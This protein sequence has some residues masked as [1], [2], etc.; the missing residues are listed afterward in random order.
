MGEAGEY[1]DS[2]GKSQSTGVILLRR[3]FARTNLL[4]HLLRQSFPDGFLLFPGDEPG[5]IAGGN[6]FLLHH[7]VCQPQFRRDAVG[8]HPQSEAKGIVENIALEIETAVQNMPPAAPAIFDLR[9]SIVFRWAQ[10]MP[11]ER[12]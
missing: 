4:V 1:T 6:G 10:F 5:R 2:V 8:I 12:F 7:L 3:N 11:V 9:R